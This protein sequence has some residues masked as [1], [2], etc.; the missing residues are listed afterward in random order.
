MASP[1]WLAWPIWMLPPA[2]P[3]GLGTQPHTAPQKSLVQRDF[4]NKTTHALSNWE[5]N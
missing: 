2:L 5:G 1:L 4:W 3:L